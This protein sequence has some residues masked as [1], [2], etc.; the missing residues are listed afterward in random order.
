MGQN[1]LDLV[2]ALPAAPVLNSTS[3][4]MTRIAQTV[5]EDDG[6]RVLGSGWE[7]QGRCPHKSG[8]HVVQRAVARV[9][10]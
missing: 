1:E 6:G 5:N 2:E 7:Q 3:P 10:T 9:E 8:R 4:A